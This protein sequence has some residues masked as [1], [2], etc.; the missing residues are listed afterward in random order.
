MSMGMIIY[1][2]VVIII[3]IGTTR[4]LSSD[5]SEDIF[6]IKFL[7]FLIG[8]LFVV[9]LYCFIEF[10]DPSPTP[11]DVYSGKTTLEYTVVDGVKTDSC[12]VWKK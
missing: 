4:I 7:S 9:D 5:F 6:V 10:L 8:I 11:I 1:L 2:T 12:V 3:L